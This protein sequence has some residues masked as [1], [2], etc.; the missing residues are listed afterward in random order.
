MPKVETFGMEVEFPIVMFGTYHD[1]ISSF[2]RIKR[3]LPGKLY[4][5]AT[6]CSEY[7]T[8]VH[9]NYDDL[10]DELLS[11]FATISEA[12][13]H[14]IFFIGKFAQVP[15]TFS[16]HIHIGKRE[17]WKNN[18]IKKV[19]R[20]LHGLQTLMELLSQNAKGSGLADPR[21]PFRDFYRYYP[22][23][24]AG[25]T[26]ENLNFTWNEHKT[27]E[28]R[29]PPSSDFFHLLTLLVIEKAWLN[30]Y[31]NRITYDFDINFTNAVKKG[32]SGQ[33]MIIAGDEVYE[34]NG[35]VY[36]A[37][38]LSKIESEIKQELKNISQK[39]RKKVEKYISFLKRAPLSSVLSS[40]TTLNLKEMAE[41]LIYHEELFI[42]GIKF[43]TIEIPAKKVTE[44]T[45]AEIVK[46][47]THSKQYSSY[48]KVKSFLKA[49]RCNK[50]E[51]MSSEEDKELVKK[52]LF[53][54]R[55]E[56]II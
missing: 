39:R 44:K 37:A 13:N 5:D 21:Q 32:L 49:I 3:D 12:T 8:S 23:S 45:I 56:V 55:L 11:A 27:V 38:M 30:K 43:K 19:L 2:S 31:N 9:D 54:K 10:V 17:G 15:A 16:G 28:N 1:W 34:V 42:K 14:N 47:V 46:A 50:P 22:I 33:Y 4:R 52:V 25:V 53:S 20:S 48:L 18:E 35:Y 26:R 41:K 51:L 6:P 29:I 36:V 40:K 24:Y 7:A